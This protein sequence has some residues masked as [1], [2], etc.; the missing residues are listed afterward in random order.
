[1][2]NVF[3][4]V[5]VAS[6]AAIATTALALEALVIGEKPP[7]LDVK[8]WVQGE[9]VVLEQLQGK[10]AVLIEVWASW[11]EPSKKSIPKLSK[12]AEKHKDDLVVVG[13][14]DEKLE[15]IKE[16]AKDGKFKYHVACDV[17]RNTLTP[18]MKGLKQKRPYSFV[19]DKAGNLAWHGETK[20]GAERVVERV[21]A[22][23]FDAE[24]AKSIV[25]LQEKVEDSALGE[26]KAQ[27]AKDADALL[28]A[29]PGNVKGIEVKFKLYADA[30]DG[31][32]CK[33]FVEKTL[34]KIDD[35]WTALNLVAWK[36]ATVD[37]SLR[38]P[39]VALKAAK[40]AAELTDSADAA[41]LDTLARVYFELGM[42]DE[43]VA[44]QT[45][46]VSA[47][48]ATEDLKTTLAYYQSCVEARKA[49]K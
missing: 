21:L 24:K 15:D 25:T 27:T 14:S 35:D 32:G 37:F 2:R 44:A 26:D 3:G 22:G 31:P 33:A 48:G 5:A 19:L 43:A 6:V 42:V 11:S 16:F 23:K 40:R 34:P 20:D 10:K 47:D 28:D 46:A 39:L 45:K 9:P 30:K 29:D 12:L 4:F 13:V 1:M 38:Q 18:Y 17:E 41:V 49:A 8:E 36:L 7:E